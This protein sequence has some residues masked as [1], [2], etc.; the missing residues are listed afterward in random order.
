LVGGAVADATSRAVVATVGDAVLDSDGA[1]AFDAVLDE[2]AAAADA[3][4]DEGAAAADAVLDEGAAA[5]DA[6][7][8]EGAAAADAVTV[9]DAGA[10]IRGGT[11]TRAGAAPS[12]DAAGGGGAGAST[13]A[14]TGEV[15]PGGSCQP[16]RCRRRAANVAVTA[17]APAAR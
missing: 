14:V 9:G 1:A 12:T 17:M 3:V 6:V 11:G 5:A 10:T 2:G 16:A 15:A 8:D 4:L 7:L 13:G